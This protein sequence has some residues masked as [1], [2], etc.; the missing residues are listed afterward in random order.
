MIAGS[1]KPATPEGYA[2]RC[3]THYLVT[4]PFSNPASDDG[5]YRFVTASIVTDNYE[6]VPGEISQSQFKVISEQALQ[7]IAKSPAQTP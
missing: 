5:K 1:C 3:I 2:G 6:N 4:A 7:S